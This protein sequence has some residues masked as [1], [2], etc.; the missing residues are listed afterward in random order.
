MHS[1]SWLSLRADKGGERFWHWKGH[2]IDT[3]VMSIGLPFTLVH[4]L[5][6]WAI[7]KGPR[8]EK[9]EYR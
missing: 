9:R 1:A 4:L 6:C 7:I 3:L 5:M 8:S 2:I